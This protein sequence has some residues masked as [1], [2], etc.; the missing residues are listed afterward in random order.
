MATCTFHPDRETFRSCSRCGRPAC[1]ECLIDAPVGA[2]CVACVRESRPAA[3]QQ[4][5]M[6]LAEPLLVTKLII[7]TLAAVHFYGLVR[8]GGTGNVLSGTSNWL[9]NNFALY[10][11]SVKSG[12]WY[13]IITSG[14]LHGSLLHLGFNSFAIWNLGRTLEGAIGRWRYAALF[15]VSVL[16]GSAG[17]LLLSPNVPTIGASGGAFGL[18]A[19]AVVGMHARGVP[20]R[21]NGWLPPMV[22]NL[23]FT[24]SIPGISIGGHLGG[25][26][27]GGIVGYVIIGRR[28]RNRQIDIAVLVAVGVFAVA[29]ALAAAQRGVGG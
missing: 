22:I 14:F 8:Q 18:M 17:A 11:P 1:Y 27:A 10:G 6:K 9:V 28:M 5:R 25:I 16:G 12:E 29:V 26:V 15:F 24:V 13:R 3:S 4:L 2:Q 21:A 23:L 19:A 20:M 7:A